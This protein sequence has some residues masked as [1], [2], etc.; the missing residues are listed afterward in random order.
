MKKKILISAL[1][2]SGLALVGFSVVAAGGEQLRAHGMAFLGDHGGWEGHHAMFHLV[3]D[4]NLDAEQ[5]KHIDAV[6]EILMSQ[7]EGR[8]DAR[9][10]H[11]QELIERVE[12]G[13]ADSTEARQMIDQHLEAIRDVA[14]RSSDEIVALVNS[15]DNEQR[16]KVVEHLQK[17]RE[18][19]G[20]HHGE[21]FGH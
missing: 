15:L 8:A 1:V 17:L 7:W 12:Q 11:L 9:D 19:M 10:M 2:V 21:H 16:A 20:E 18:K 6:H 5:Q 13:T 3:E 14:Y 4:L